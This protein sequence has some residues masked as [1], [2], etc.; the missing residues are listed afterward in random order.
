MV[1]MTLKLSAERKTITSVSKDIRVVVNRN[2]K[3]P[4]VLSYSFDNSDVAEGE[5]TKLT[6]VVEDMDSTTAQPPRLQFENSTLGTDAAVYMAFRSVNQDATT[7]KWTIVYDFNTRENNIT[8]NQKRM[9]ASF[10]VIS[11][12]GARTTVQSRDIYV[13]N[14]LKE[15]VSSLAT[16][17][18]YTF[19]KGI[20][21]RKN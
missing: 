20:K 16:G 18:T 3:I 1:P 21:Y 15:A 12:Y 2:F 7:K 14:K 10:V 11:R 4:K 17:T 8:D 19:A 5:A 9:T 13:N 6:V